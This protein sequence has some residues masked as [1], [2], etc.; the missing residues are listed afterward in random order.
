MSNQQI[1][2]IYDFECRFCKASVDWLALKL[3]FTAHPFQSADLAPFNL[4]REECAKEVI[5]I[6]SDEIFRG[7]HAVTLLL[8]AR[9]NRFPAAIIAI[10]GPLGSAIYRWV[11][12]HRGSILV[13]TLTKILERA[14]S[15]KGKS[16]RANGDSSSES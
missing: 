15:G 9:G 3:Q 5:A 10:S 11:A 8:R 2:V 12:T 14:I 6:H 4:T 1:T 16:R 7:A 13:K